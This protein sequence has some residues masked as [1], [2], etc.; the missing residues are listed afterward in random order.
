[1]LQRRLSTKRSR[2]TPPSLKQKITWDNAP[3]GGFLCAGEDEKNPRDQLLFDY[4]LLCHFFSDFP[5]RMM[6]ILLVREQGNGAKVLKQLKSLGWSELSS[7][8]ASLKNNDELLLSNRIN[9]H[10]TTPYFW[11]EYDERYVSRLYEQPGSFFTVVEEPNEYA[12]YYVNHKQEVRRRDIESPEI[13]PILLSLYDIKEGLP[14]SSKVPL[15]SV[16]GLFDR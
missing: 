4:N 5:K 10:F 13:N 15:T 3:T 2:S 7:P 11:G 8:S 6:K 14:R 16:L 1:M 12:L 9:P